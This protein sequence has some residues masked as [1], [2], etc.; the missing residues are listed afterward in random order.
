MGILVSSLEFRAFCEKARNFLVSHCIIPLPPSGKIKKEDIASE[1]ICLGLPIQRLLVNAP[2]EFFQINWIRIRINKNLWIRIRIYPMR[3]HITGI[4]ACFRTIWDPL[5]L[6]VV[7]IRPWRLYQ[8][9]GYFLLRI[10]TEKLYCT[11]LTSQEK[12]VHRYL[13]FVQEV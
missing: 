13:L 7:L 9:I 6:D 5:N 12:E 3:I 8:H 10:A 11:K 2:L 1:C 4:H